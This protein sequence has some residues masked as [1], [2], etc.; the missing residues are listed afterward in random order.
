MINGWNWV[1]GHFIFDSAFFCRFVAM[2]VKIKSF[3][4]RPFASYIYKAI[5]KGMMTAVADQEAIFKD[6]MR[7]GSKTVFGEEHRLGEVK[8]YEE[9][10]QA[11]PIRDYEQF[12]PY[13]AQIKEGRHNILWQGRPIYL[14]KTSGTTSGVKYIPISKDSISN[15][16]NTARNALLCYMSSTGNMS[17]SDGKMI[18]LSGS[19]ELERI[20]GIPT[21][22]L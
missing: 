4:A 2:N 7:V 9:F 14:A 3:L 22:R 8:T 18:F 15:H 1:N 10:K 17:F 20:G 19:P 6:L 11:V 5:Q 16:M 13:I 12:S 21:G